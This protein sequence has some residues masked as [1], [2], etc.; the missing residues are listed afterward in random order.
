[1]LRGNC[2]DKGIEVYIAL[3]YVGA[4]I[5]IYLS[6]IVSRDTR[7]ASWFHDNE[8]VQKVVIV[9]GTTD[10]VNVGGDFQHC[11]NI[12]FPITYYVR[13]FSFG[14]LNFYMSLHVYSK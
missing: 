2:L 13:D 3:L 7:K 4:C 11:S 1:M 14:K 6:F 12:T 5:L 9:D 8:Y 10:C